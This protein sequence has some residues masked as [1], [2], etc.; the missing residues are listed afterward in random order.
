MK[1]GKKKTVTR[2]YVREKISSTL[3]KKTSANKILKKNPVKH[4]LGMDT[5]DE[6]P[7]KERH[8]NFYQFL[9]SYQCL[10][11]SA[12]KKKAQAKIYLIIKLLHNQFNQFYDILSLIWE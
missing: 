6:I 12:V 9:N 2:K 10:T 3:I 8:Y 5:L 1:L 11:C 7:I 4:K